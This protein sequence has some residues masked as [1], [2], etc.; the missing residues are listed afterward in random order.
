M[1]LIQQGPA[2]PV[3]KILGNLALAQLS[4][5]LVKCLEEQLHH[6]GLGFDASKD[7]AKAVNRR[8]RKRITEGRI[9]GPLRLANLVEQAQLD[10][11]REHRDSHFLTRIRETSGTRPNRHHSRLVTPTA[12]RK[13]DPGTTGWKRRLGG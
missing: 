1:E 11:F 12:M 6:L 10:D 3:Q 2:R 5:D 8:R 13:R 7:I 4:G 9:G